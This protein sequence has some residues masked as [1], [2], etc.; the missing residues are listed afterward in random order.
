MSRY[1]LDTAARIFLEKGFDDTSM[2]GVAAAAAVPKSTVYHRHGDKR[3]LLRAVIEDRVT[4]WS[5]V[6]S[7]RNWML[8]EDLQQ[9]L[10]CYGAWL[11]L[12]STSPEVRA[13]V[14]LSIIAWHGVDDPEHRPDIVAFDDMASIIERDIVVFGPRAGINATRPRDVAIAFMALLAGSLQFRRSPT[15]M[16]DDEA[17]VSAAAAVDL[18]LHGRTVW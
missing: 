7:R 16:T 5:L 18:L 3:A 13:F 14:G 15:P 11:L 4:T 6:A 10:T 9:R 12:W 8:T 17:G 2:E 1:I